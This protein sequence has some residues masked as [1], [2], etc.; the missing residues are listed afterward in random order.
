M[1]SRRDLFRLLGMV[2]GAPLIRWRAPLLRPSDQTYDAVSLQQASTPPT[3]AP[4]IPFSNGVVSGQ[5]LY[6]VAGEDTG[7]G[8]YV[9]P[10]PIVDYVYGGSRITSTTRT[11]VANL[12]I[13]AGAMGANGLVRVIGSVLIEHNNNVGESIN[14]TVYLGSTRMIN[15]GQMANENDWNSLITE[16]HY[17]FMLCN[18]GSTSSQILTGISWG[19]KQ[20]GSQDPS[21]RYLEGAAAEDSTGALALDLSI[22]KDSDTIAYTHKYTIMR[23]AEIT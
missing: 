15:S 6:L 21:P 9:D 10:F 13:P 12:T 2:G 17:D 20:T 5:N 23:L 8:G 19:A 11:D 3:G 18:V 1:T 7:G 4:Y 16:A 22:T 14:L